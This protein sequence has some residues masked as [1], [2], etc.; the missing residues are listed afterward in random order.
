MTCRA[1]GEVEEV[2]VV[3]RQ[4]TIV[5]WLTSSRWAL[6]GMAVPFAGLTMFSLADPK[7]RPPPKA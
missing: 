6:L 4:A 3:C 5:D 7:D 1:V 2:V